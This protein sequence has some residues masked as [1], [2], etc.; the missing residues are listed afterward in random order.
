MYNNQN[1]LVVVAHG[2]LN[3]HGMMR[4]YLLYLAALP[5]NSSSSA[6]PYSSTVVTYTGAT[7]PSFKKARESRHL[8]AGLAL[9]LVAHFVRL[10]LD[11]AR[12]L[13]EK[14]RAY[15]Q[16]KRQWTHRLHVN[17]KGLRAPR[18]AQAIY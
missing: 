15:S 17:A 1:E 7:P 14:V 10:R 9:A 5:A 8:L 3:G 16:C 13:R 11:R 6:T 18:D 12:A 2:R 4:I